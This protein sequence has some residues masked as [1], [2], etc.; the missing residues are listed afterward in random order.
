MRTT[1]RL[2]FVAFLINL[3]LCV[4]TAFGQ[5]IGPFD[6]TRGLSLVLLSTDDVRFQAS[7]RNGIELEGGRVALIFPPRVLMGW[8][9]DERGRSLIGTPG[10]RGVFRGPIDVS[11]LDDIDASALQAI[12]F[13]NSAVSGELEKKLAAEW[14]AQ[15]PGVLRDDSYPHPEVSYFDY[16][17]NLKRAFSAQD[18]RGTDDV[19]WRLPRE[20]E[21][22]SDNMVGTVTV[23]FFFVESNGDSTDENKYTWSAPAHTEILNKAASGLAWWVSQANSYGRSLSFT[24][25]DYPGT[26]SRCQTWYEPVLHPSTDAYNWVAEIMGKFGYTGSHITR[27]AAYNTWARANYGTDWAYSVFVEYNPPPA[28]SQFT[29]GY[30]AWAYLGGPYTNLL[31]RSFG[32]SFDIV[33]THESGHIF[34]ACDE[35]YEAG[36]GGCTSCGICSHGVIN[37]NC[38]YCNTQSVPCM[39]KANSPSLCTFTPGHIGWFSTPI[40]AHFSHTTL[41]P[42]GNGNGIA[43]PGETI[44]MGITLKNYGLSATGINA[45]LTSADPYIKITSNSSSYPDIPIDK[46]GS[47]LVYYAFS[48]D[49]GTPTGH[50]V[51]FNL[52]IHAAGYDTVSTFDLYI[53]ETPILLVDDDAGSSYETYYQSAIASTGLNY[54]LWSVKTSGSPTLAEL[55]KHRATV[56]FTSAE[57]GFTLTGTDESNLTSYLNSGG[58][59]FF[60]SQEYLSERFETFA[61]EILRV[62]NCMPDYWNNALEAGVAGDPISDGMNLHM[63]YP[64]TDYPDDIVPGV[65]ASPVF[66]NSSN[67]AGALR[68]PSAG[69]APYK[70]VFMA[71][72]FEAIA[73][74]AAPNNK[75][76]VMKKVLDWLLLPQDYQPP[77]VRVI[78]PNGKE[79][80]EIGT[81][82][83]IRWEA[84]DS[85]GIDSVAILYSLDGGASY[86]DT[87][88]AST[89]NDSSFVW[90]I[91]DTVSE[92]ARVKVVA[93][94]KWLNSSADVS[95]SVFTIAVP[96]SVNRHV[97]KEGSPVFSLF[98]Y[99]NPSMPET[100]IRLSLDRDVIGSLRI[101]DVRGRLVKTIAQGKLKSGSHLYL[102]GGRND[103]DRK[104][105][106]G[107]Y[108]LSYEGGGRKESRKIV[109]LR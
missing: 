72:P 53:G 63:H 66:M 1:T 80:W 88:T 2:V 75:N 69:T 46:T 101:F 95:D 71:F 45:T 103:E 82:Q 81:T 15:E 6:W 73:D 25:I 74:S 109:L 99:P 24:I 90:L 106:P 36:Y 7:L 60:S 8:F 29:N 33:F 84:S 48:S 100:Q 26:D 16:I 67:F 97:L 94:D 13:F 108:I 87:I 61:N 31:Y 11:S 65:N 9:S 35:Y 18:S 39:M 23:T 57:A 22:N 76:T 32:W 70:V 10:V 85:S 56:W 107:V 54:L 44:S 43:E 89:P 92:N 55:M 98:S 30:A 19:L 27:V 86:P 17:E 93:C 5:G 28:P 42:L 96:A 20:V 104:L 59:L 37:G 62:E 34:W 68:F 78:A 105:S 47:S 83:E 50:L 64:F 12:N 91:P 4:S 58:T 77:S 3:L 51:S 49:P 38:E 102:W 52:Q 14:K 40:L 79:R 21:G 41:D